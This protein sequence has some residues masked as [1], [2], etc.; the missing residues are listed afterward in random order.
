MI[1]SDRLAIGLEHPSGN[2]AGARGY[3]INPKPRTE[4]GKSGK[5]GKSSINFDRIDTGRKEIA[6]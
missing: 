1:P 2:S 4:Y 5:S 3:L 6:Q